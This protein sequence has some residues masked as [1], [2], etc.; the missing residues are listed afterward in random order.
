MLHPPGSPIDRRQSDLVDSITMTGYKRPANE[1]QLREWNG[2]VAFVCD[3]RDVGIQALC[4]LDRKNLLTSVS[5]TRPFRQLQTPDSRLQVAHAIL[6]GVRNMN[7]LQSIIG[8]AYHEMLVQ[9]HWRP[10]NPC[11]DSTKRGLPSS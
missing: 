8:K 4:D 9:F 5:V 3:T 11:L 7:D 6:K 2:I 1:S 10:G